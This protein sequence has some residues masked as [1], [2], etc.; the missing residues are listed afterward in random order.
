MIP[1]MFIQ[2]KEELLIESSITINDMKVNLNHLTNTME[3]EFE[4]NLGSFF[5]LKIML[6][7]F[8][9][10]KYVWIRTTKQTDWQDVTPNKQ[11]YTLDADYVVM[12]ITYDDLMKIVNNAIKYE[13]VEEFNIK[14]KQ[15]NYKI[16]KDIKISRFSKTEYGLTVLEFILNGCEIE[17][18][19]GEIYP[20][21]V[22]DENTKVL[23]N[24]IHGNYYIYDVV[25]NDIDYSIAILSPSSFTKH[26]LFQQT[27]ELTNMF[28][29]DK[30][31]KTI[32]SDYL[33]REGLILSDN[34]TTSMQKFFNKSYQTEYK[35]YI[36]NIVRSNNIYTHI[37]IP[38]TVYK[39]HSIN[40]YDLK[41]DYLITGKFD[42][43]FKKTDTYHS[44]LVLELLS[45]KNQFGKN[46]EKTFRVEI[47]TINLIKLLKLNTTR[48]RL[49]DYL[50]FYIDNNIEPM[51]SMFI[52]Q[53]EDNYFT[54]SNNEFI[55]SI[56]SN[57][58]Q[59]IIYDNY[60]MTIPG[61]KKLFN[62]VVIDDRV[63][64]NKISYEDKTITLNNCNHKHQ[65]SFDN[66]NN[67]PF[68]FSNP[69]SD[70]LLNQK[71]TAI[72]G[73]KPKQEILSIEFD[74][75]TPDIYDDILLLAKH[76]EPLD[77]TVGEL[78]KDLRRMDMSI[79]Y[80]FNN[81]SVVFVYNQKRDTLY[82]ITMSNQDSSKDLEGIEKGTLVIDS[83]DEEVLKRFLLSGSISEMVIRTMGV[84]VQLD[85]KLNLYPFVSYKTLNKTFYSYKDGVSEQVSNIYGDFTKNI[86]MYA[87]Y[88]D[89]SNT[90][91]EV[92]FG[93][94]ATNNVKV[95]DVTVKSNS[96]E[97]EYISLFDNKL[98]T[99]EFFK[100]DGLKY[101]YTDI[102]GNN[103][104][105]EEYNGIDKETESY[106]N[107]RFIDKAEYCFAID[108]NIF[109]YYIKNQTIMLDNCNIINYNDKV[110]A[111]KVINA[112]KTYTSIKQIAE[113]ELEQQENLSMLNLSW[114]KEIINSDFSLEECSSKLDKCED[115]MVIKTIKQYN[116]NIEMY[117]KNVTNLN[118]IN[119]PLGV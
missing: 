51:S 71:E 53:E 67:N 15:F 101:K 23:P 46:I 36:F 29:S 6:N 11:T 74:F 73:V 87:A 83:V 50:N 38:F 96:I 14:S 100:K 2:K 61:I 16:D 62:D 92:V 7:E 75:V 18:F 94:F 118:Y 33:Y 31:L 98:K 22:I 84:G 3:I 27:D 37:S 5:N 21:M 39:H 52:S 76:T 116:D 17:Y 45:P 119:K 65:V 104:S 20:E 60:N 28:L 58:L 30:R 8:D 12:I 47:P 81:I 117:Q 89:D 4:Y 72:F 115:S 77:Y 108:I 63:S 24:R 1:L 70:F 66:I 43:Y 82:Y 40:I 13:D 79:K 32:Y 112:D 88:K 25:L 105:L 93:I 85:H 95:T 78:R 80:N 103:K 19:E 54:A 41:N 91:Q 68:I 59:D 44:V 42:S 107:I 26:Y 57:R 109:N 9:Q 69:E 56:N 111:V 34:S 49:I 113:E 106:G 90:L 35:Q 110:F 114:N 99:I 10:P 97:L 102:Y 48:Y 64:F 55:F 86:N